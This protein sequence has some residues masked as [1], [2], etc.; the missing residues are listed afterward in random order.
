MENELMPLNA[1][2]V[3]E[4]SLVAVFVNGAP[5]CL[6]GKREKVLFTYPVHPLLRDGVNR[7][8]YEY[9]PFD[10]AARSF[11]PHQGVHVELNMSSAH[12]SRVT[13]LSAQ[14]SDR[15]GAMVP[16]PA[17]LVSGEAPVLGNDIIAASNRFRAQTTAIQFAS[18]VM[19]ENTFRLTSEFQVRMPGLGNV[20]WAET[21]VLS[22]E[23][24]IRRELYDAYQALHSILQARDVAGFIEL[25]RPALY[26]IARM[27]GYSDENS[28]VGR[29]FELN[30]MGG[31]P[32]SRM[33]PLPGWEEFQTMPLRW[34]STGQLV[35]TFTDQIQYL[36]E[37]TGERTGG[38][39]VFFAR[40]RGE[41]LRI[42][43]SLDS[44][45]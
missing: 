15:E 29:V 23:P 3:A 7:L 42:H 31:K 18:R 26:R 16:A 27:N 4:N 8:D 33:K 28:V 44:G 2:V 30:P 5:F 37:A 19:D 36:D 40:Q 21:A 39:R 24:D 22:A 34:G 14:Y 6:S 25:A 1:T 10:N 11:T 41:P 35:A 17:A 43:Y 45:Q 38:M 32:G 12:M 20:P 9:T 13:V